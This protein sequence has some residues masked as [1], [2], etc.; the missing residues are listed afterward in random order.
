MNQ[1]QLHG[2]SDKSKL[3]TV[4]LPHSLSTNVFALVK[5]GP[6]YDPIGKD[7][8]SHFVEHM[9]FKGT[10]KRDNSYALLSEIE[11][12]GG[13]VNAFT[14]G[15]TNKYWIKVPKE[16]TETAIDNLTDRLF[17]SLF[18]EVDIKTEK[19]VVGE[20]I[21]IIHSNPNQLIWEA[22]SEIIWKNPALRRFYNGNKDSVLGIKR[23][24]IIDFVNNYYV[25]ENII[26]VVAGSIKPL[27]IK[28]LF[29]KYIQS[30]KDKKTPRSLFPNK[31][32]LLEQS[33]RK[34]KIY[35][36]GTENITVALGFNTV[37]FNHEDRPVLEVITSMLGGGM[38]SRLRKKVMEPGLTYSIESWS[39]NLQDEGY[40][41]IR[42]STSKDN[43]NKVLAIIFAE[44]ANL[45]EE[46]VTAQELNLAKGYTQGVIR[47]NTETSYDFAEWFA[48]NY[49]LGGSLISP[50]EKS[51]GYQSVSEKQIQE[52]TQKYF[53][54][55]KIKIALIGDI[56]E[57]SLALN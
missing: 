39:A 31:D 51:K 28:G 15:E 30:G 55:N 25:G 57:E 23:Q 11:T 41:M 33:G 13:S 52:A 6:R 27:K 3:I 42:F 34:I 26:F 40:L 4:N 29:E 7:G 46:P 54:M 56:K 32:N 16:I 43:L 2:L 14:Y 1:V 24:D 49:F 18:R 50:E 10:K 22:W 20:E 8:L 19:G 36:S 53:D 48:V 47:V 21:R 35:S 37:A 12:Y 17:N 44:I 38:S 5:A 45:K 9:M